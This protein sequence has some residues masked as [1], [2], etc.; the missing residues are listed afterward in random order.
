[1]PLDVDESYS[2]GLAEAWRM[3]SRWRPE[4]AA[5]ST[6][7]APRVRGAILD[8]VRST[9]RV[10]RITRQKAKAW[11]VA[12][13]QLQCRLGRPVTDDDRAAT[14]GMTLDEIAAA[15]RAATPIGETSLDETY[16]D[17]GDDASKT[18][19]ATTVDPRSECPLR[20]SSR[21]DLLR[22]VTKGLRKVPRLA[23]ILHFVEG[24][25]MKE[26]GRELALSESRISQMLA[27]IIADL[28]V[29]LGGRAEELS[30]LL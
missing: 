26:V 21:L 12:E 15:R 13:Q 1:M 30:A 20:R 6:F 25:T 2:I 7:L 5:L 22:V 28:R 17:R 29:R 10:P 8:W 11:S 18:F 23:V 14:W 16:F 27:G 3:L 4:Q 24:R 9:D 19:A